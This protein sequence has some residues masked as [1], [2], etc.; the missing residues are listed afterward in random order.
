MG[1]NEQITRVTVEIGFEIKITRANAHEETRKGP[2]IIL[3]PL[4]QW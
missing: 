4:S 3:G 1:D 2:L